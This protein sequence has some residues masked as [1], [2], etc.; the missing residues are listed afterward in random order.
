MLVGGRADGFPLES[1]DVPFAA[2]ELD[3]SRGKGGL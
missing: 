2:R 3:L 1:D